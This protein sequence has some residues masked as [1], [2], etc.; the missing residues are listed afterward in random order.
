[1]RYPQ[2]VSDVIERLESSGAEAYIVGGSV[3][4]II[5]GTEPHDFD[6]TTSALPD[7][8]LRVF[9]DHRTIPTGLKHGTVTVISGGEPIEI[10]TFRI[11]GDYK[12]NRH[13][14]SVVFS[15]NLQDDLSRRDFTVNAMAYSPHTGIIDLFDGKADLITR[16]IRCVGDPQKRFTEDALRVMR[17]LRFAAVLDFK[18]EEYT[19]SALHKLFP[20]LQNI[21]AERIMTE[22]NKLLIAENPH[23]ILD[24]YSD[25]FLFIL[26]KSTYE[27]VWKENL[28]LLLNTPCILEIRLAVLLRGFDDLSAILRHLKY[29]NKT[30]HTVTDLLSMSHLFLPETKTDVKK[31]LA[32]YGEELFRLFLKFKKADGEPLFLINRANEYL[33]E[34]IANNECYTLKTLAVTGK[35][36]QNHFPLQGRQLGE[37]LNAL[38]DAVICEKCINDRTALLEFVTLHIK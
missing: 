22:L 16:T 26:G 18:I 35:D 21:A 17:A 25:V 2:Y 23:D 28:K 38:L 19:A 37:V 7:E 20:L 1:M 24:E 33:S 3:R 5:I 36:L 8:I 14:E 10:T 12:D 4:D 34:I 31:M 6:V 32:E 13:P 27:T 29:D 9:A 11:D 15:S 30:R